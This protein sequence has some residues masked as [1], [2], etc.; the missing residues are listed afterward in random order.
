MTH[1]KTLGGD[2]DWKQLALE[3]HKALKA[4]F[5]SEA[6]WSLEDWVYNVRESADFSDHEGSSWEHPDVV[7]YSNALEACE[8]VIA[9]G[10]ELGLTNDE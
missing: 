4:L 2:M 3:Q 10:N 6:P 8:A 5:D 9:K 1:S 7:Q